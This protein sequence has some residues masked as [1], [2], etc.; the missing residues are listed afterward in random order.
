MANATV[1]TS[2]SFNLGAPFRA[3]GN[4]FVA[5]ME[6]NARVKK[7]EFLNSLSDEQLAKRGLK[8][9]DI[10]REVFKDSFYL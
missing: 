4:F 6:A 3:I 7:V 1:N 5:I 2:T 10:V 9:E 8:R